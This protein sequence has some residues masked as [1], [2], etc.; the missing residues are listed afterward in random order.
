MPCGHVVLD[1]RRIMFHPSGPSFTELAVQALSSTRRGY[2]LLAPRFEHTPFR[3]PDTVL[4]AVEPHLEALGPFA[5]ALDLC[6][7]TGAGLQMLRE[8]CLERLVG[9]DFSVGML[10]VARVLLEDEASIPLADARTPEI[11]LVLGDVLEMA[12]TNTFDVVTCFGAL[13]HIAEEDEQR[14]VARIAQVLRPGGRFV[15][16]TSP[17][18][19]LRDRRTWIAH[20]FN[21]AMRVRNIVLRPRF[22]M[23]YLTF[24]LERATALLEGHGFEVESHAA[25]L[26]APY[27]RSC[28]VVATLRA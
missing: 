19:G 5:T 26:D 28:V 7:G 1:Q 12:W 27:D 15:F 24:T 20:A 4:G 18:P 3:T 11:E 21:A 16:V 13:G 22:I 25:G 17:R 23:Y 9:I 10:D 6:C 8:H 2:D 14:F